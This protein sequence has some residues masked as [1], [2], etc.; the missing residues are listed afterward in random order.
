MGQRRGKMAS[1]VRSP[2]IEGPRRCRGAVRREGATGERAR[3]NGRRRANDDDDDFVCGLHRRGVFI[4][5]IHA[6]PYLIVRSLSY[7]L[8]FA[9]IH[10]TSARAA[11]FVRT[12]VINCVTYGEE[13]NFR[14]TPPPRALSSSFSFTAAAIYKFSRILHERARNNTTTHPLPTTTHHRRSHA[15]VRI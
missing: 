3:T 1:V 12:Y 2:P 6:R 15:G 13:K 10:N 14:L 7:S 4:I 9:V 5:F 8:S 11:T